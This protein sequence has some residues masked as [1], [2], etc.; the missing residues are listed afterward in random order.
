MSIHRVQILSYLISTKSEN[1]AIFNRCSVKKADVSQCKSALEQ[2]HYVFPVTDCI[3]LEMI[4][5]T[6][7]D[8]T[9]GC[10]TFPFA[11]ALKMKKAHER[12][13]YNLTV[14]FRLAVANY[15]FIL[16]DVLI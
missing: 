16:W 1:V 3:E 13:L 2:K 8:A 5:F 9:E 11:A 4:R 14:F 6:Y 10:A 7:T 12:I 15:S